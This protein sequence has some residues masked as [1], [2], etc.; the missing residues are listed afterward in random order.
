LVN[1]RPGKL[2]MEEKKD[3]KMFWNLVLWRRPIIW[4]P[5][6]FWLKLPH[7]KLV[8]FAKVQQQYIDKAAAIEM[9]KAQ[10]LAEIIGVPLP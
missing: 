7:D 6:P 4:D 3:E 1:F 9:E 8:E 5:A 2:K 10:K